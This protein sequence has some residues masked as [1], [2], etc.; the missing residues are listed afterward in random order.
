[1]KKNSK[2]SNKQDL[3]DVWGALNVFNL[4]ARQIYYLPQT[5]TVDLDNLVSPNISSNA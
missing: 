5:C 3:S 2:N 1:M 4:T